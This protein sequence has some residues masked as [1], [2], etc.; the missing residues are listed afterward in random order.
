MLAARF[1]CCTLCLWVAWLAHTANGVQSI[2]WLCNCCWQ[3][4][5]CGVNCSGP[6]TFLCKLPYLFSY[7]AL[8]SLQFCGGQLLPC[9]H[10]LASFWWDP[11]KIMSTTSGLS[12]AQASC[13]LFSCCH[14][15]F[16]SFGPWV[17]CVHF[18]S[19]WPFFWG[20]RAL[21]QW[22]PPKITSSPGVQA[23]SLCF[24]S[25]LIMTVLVEH[26]CGAANGLH[27]VSPDPGSWLDDLL[28]SCPCPWLPASY[29]AYPCWLL[30]LP[31]AVLTWGCLRTQNVNYRRS[32]IQ[33]C[34]SMSWC[35]S[36]SCACVS[37]VCGLMSSSSY[38]ACSSKTVLAV[39]KFSSIS[40]L[41]QWSCTM[42]AVQPGLKRLFMV[43]RAFLTALTACSDFVQIPVLMIGAQWFVLMHAYSTLG[44]WLA[45]SAVLHLPSLWY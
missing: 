31:L 14:M 42:L 19:S 4:H 36:Q 15:P 1:L 45:L 16:G 29:C 26:W 25:G 9:L 17:C 23:A 13:R 12:F 7:L 5:G 40:S 28:P 2:C 41:V 33:G 10:C 32:F 20:A 30:P 18:E 3:R 35:S 43:L 21:A 38:C 6:A 37:L 34:S 39:D 22:L 11:D 24:W 27:S 44:V 8:W